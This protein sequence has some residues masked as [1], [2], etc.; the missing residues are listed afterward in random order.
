MNSQC[1]CGS[2][3]VVVMTNHDHAHALAFEQLCMQQT[4]WA[5]SDHNGDAAKGDVQLRVSIDAACQWF[6]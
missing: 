6:R 4:N 1:L 3:P 5:I 2:Q